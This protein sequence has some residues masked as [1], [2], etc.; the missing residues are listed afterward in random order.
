MR[1]GI[2]LA[3]IWALAGCSGGGGGDSSHGYRGASPA[4]SSAWAGQWFGSGTRTGSSEPIA[5]SAMI[6]KTGDMQLVVSPAVIIVPTPDPAPPAAIVGVQSF[7]RYFV[8]QANVCCES[9]FSG[10]AR[11]FNVGMNGVSIDQFT[12]SVTNGTLA[13]AFNF[14]GESYAFTLSMDPQYLQPLT[15]Q[16]LAGVYRN[17]TLSS[18]AEEV[19]ST[20]VVANDGTVTGSSVDGCIYNGKVSI[21]DPA[22]HLF[23]MHL[24]IDSCSPTSLLERNGEYDGLGTLRTQII[25]FD[26][27]S[28]PITSGA[29]PLTQTTSDNQILFYSLIGEVWLGTAAVMKP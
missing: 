10:R 27:G 1:H 3:F 7:G 5:V 20:L 25:I 16:D 29:I 9:S 26:T 24:R 18:G 21:P 22:R 2:A 15:F 12:G 6:D 4:Q 19:R 28:S 8:V 23:R 13:G 14:Q 17:T 11:A